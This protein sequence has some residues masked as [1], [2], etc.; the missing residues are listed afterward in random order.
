MPI[1]GLTDKGDFRQ[2][3]STPGALGRLFGAE[4]TWSYPERTRTVF[5]HVGKCGGASAKAALRTLPDANEFAVAHVTEPPYRSD[6]DY[7]I[8]ARAPLSRIISAYN[9]RKRLVLGEGEQ[10]NRFPGE[11][12][13]LKKY[14]SINALGEALYDEA[15]EPNA[16][17]H[18]DALKVHHIRENIS[19]YLTRLLQQCRPSQIRAVLMQETLD[20]DLE[21]LFGIHNAER[22]HDN[23]RMKRPDDL[24][25][26]AR[27]NLKAFL[28]QDYAALATLY[29]WGKIDHDTY[30]KTL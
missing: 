12:D 26:L 17:A 10:P 25:D 2:Y 13:V 22:I 21:R 7:V 30:I 18:E 15:G 27:K 4:T 5:V 28:H 8:L 9:W 23:S 6:L 29:A 1:R 16:A 19:F 3:R 11:V 20:G 14:E 24:S